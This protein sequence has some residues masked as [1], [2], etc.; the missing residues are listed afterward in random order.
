MKTMKDRM[1]YNLRC[2]CERIIHCNPGRS[3]LF[4]ICR[5]YYYLLRSARDDKNLNDE[6]F[7]IYLFL[8]K[9]INVHSMFP[10]RFY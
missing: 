8:I 3:N 2:V 9:T 1:I 10:D 4:L 5:N 7:R 6:L